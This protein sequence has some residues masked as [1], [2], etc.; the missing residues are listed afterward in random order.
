MAFCR[1]RLNAFEL[2]D[3]ASYCVK[4]VNLSALLRLKKVLRLLM[5]VYMHG[6]I[7][8]SA[9]NPRVPPSATLAYRLCRACQ[10]KVPAEGEPHDQDIFHKV[11]LFAM[12]TNSP[13]IKNLASSGKVLF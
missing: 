9:V 8:R 6:S 1:M 7:Q 12:A 13:F 4:Y 2:Q 10:K 3:P 5:L 11:T